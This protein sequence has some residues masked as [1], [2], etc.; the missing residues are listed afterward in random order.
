M[1]ELR[2]DAMHG[3][4]QECAYA[5]TQAFA[6]VL[7]NASCAWFQSSDI[8]SSVDLDGGVLNERPTTSVE[9]QPTARV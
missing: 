6:S 2:N 4:H 1:Y 8:V 9:Q 7:Q 5:S 3:V